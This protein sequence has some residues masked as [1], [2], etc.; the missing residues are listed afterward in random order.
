MAQLVA[1]ASRSLINVLSRHANEST[2]PNRNKNHPDGNTSFSK[3]S[4]YYAHLD[5]M[6]YPSDQRSAMYPIRQLR[7]SPRSATGRSRRHV[8]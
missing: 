1:D 2:M 5:P 7:A 8:N 3:G 6:K 4:S